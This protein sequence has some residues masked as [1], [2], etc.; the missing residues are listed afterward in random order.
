[1]KLV[2][3]EPP[4]G[5]CLVQDLRTKRRVQKRIRIDGLVVSGSW[6]ILDRLRDHVG[7]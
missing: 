6:T 4:P 2:E 1:M 5:Y 7:S 3:C